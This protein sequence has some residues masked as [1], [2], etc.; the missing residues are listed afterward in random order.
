MSEKKIFLHPF[1]L[2]FRYYSLRLSLRNESPSE[3][4]QM[5][6]VFLTAAILA[7]ADAIR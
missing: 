2:D 7:L 5:F 6:I 3:R 4:L 1:W